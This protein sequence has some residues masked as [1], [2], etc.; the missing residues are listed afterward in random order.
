LKKINEIVVKRVEVI[1]DS[2]PIAIVSKECVKT[3][4]SQVQ[5]VLHILGSPPFLL[6]INLVL[7][8]QNLGLHSDY[9]IEDL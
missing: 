6:Y 8:N 1:R 4:L 9:D 2:T 7:P 3:Y 5:L